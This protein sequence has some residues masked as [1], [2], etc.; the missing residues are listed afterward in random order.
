MSRPPVRTLVVPR[1]G[2]MEIRETDE[3][4]LPDGRFRAQLISMG[5]MRFLGSLHFTEHRSRVGRISPFAL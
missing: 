1:A 5:N 3:P 4:E 2:E